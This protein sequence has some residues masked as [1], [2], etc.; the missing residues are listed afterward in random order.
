MRAIWGRRQG[1]NIQRYLG[2]VQEHSYHL[3]QGQTYCKG[4][5]QLPKPSMTKSITHNVLSGP[6]G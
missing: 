6:V 5:H 2:V 3:D 4:R 1:R